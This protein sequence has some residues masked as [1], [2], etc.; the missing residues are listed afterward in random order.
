M[1]RTLKV[2]CTG[3]DQERLAETYQVVARYE[4][5][6]IVEIAKNKMADLARRY[7]V[8]DITD[9]YLIQVGD[10]TIDTAQ[11]RIDAK[12]KLRTH[13][14]YKGIKKLSTAPHHHLVQFIGPIKEEWLKEIKKAG[15]E[16]RAPHGVFTY[17]VR[18]DAKT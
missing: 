13:P 8:E 2:F 10:R 4:G 1:H 6:V 3:A 16:P 7:P 9:L 14:A 5:F 12:G 11:P 15:G 18:S 17:V